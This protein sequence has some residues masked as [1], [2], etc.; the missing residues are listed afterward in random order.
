MDLKLQ[1]WPFWPL[2][3]LDQLTY[4][5]F[6]K[7]GKALSLSFSER[8]EG[9]FKNNNNKNNNKNSN[10]NNNKNNNKKINNNNNRLVMK[11]VKTMEMALNTLTEGNSNDSFLVNLEFF[12]P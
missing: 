12:Q 5:G 1:F 10:E 11:N 2:E 6:P 8:D 9:Y 4:W 7:T 3:T